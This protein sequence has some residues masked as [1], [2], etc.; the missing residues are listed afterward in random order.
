MKNLK[1]QLEIFDS[2]SIN[3]TLESNSSSKNPMYYRVG[4]FNQSHIKYTVDPLSP[5]PVSYRIGPL[6]YS[7]GVP[8]YLTSGSTLTVRWKVQALSE[9]R[10]TGVIEQNVSI[11]LI[12]IILNNYFQPNV[13]LTYE[14]NN[15]TKV[16]RIRIPKLK[17]NPERH[18]RIFAFAFPSVF[19]RSQNSQ[20]FNLGIHFMNTGFSDL[21]KIKIVEFVP[22]IL[23]DEGTL[24]VSKK[25][26]TASFKIQS[27]NLDGKFVGYNPD[28]TIG[29]LKSGRTTLVGINMTTL[30]NDVSFGNSY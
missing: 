26:K 2:P 10:L 1:F 3:Q 29:E 23:V 18:L 21:K 8:D 5:S 25:S 11:V 27:I 13:I 12:L 24:Q 15:K 4:P 28:I 9:R 6:L 14:V 7:G 20:E 16:Q 22:W 19:P 17:I 30:H